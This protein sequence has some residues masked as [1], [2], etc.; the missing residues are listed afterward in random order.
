MIRT[1]CFSGANVV[2]L[3]T[4]R[5]GFPAHSIKGASGTFS[6]DNGRYDQNTRRPGPQPPERGPR[7][8][9]PQTGGH[10]RAFGFGQIVAGL[11]HD[12]CRGTA[13]LYGDAFDLRPAVRGDDG[14]SRRGQ[15]HGTEPRGGH[16]AEDHQQESPFDGRHRHRDQ[17]LSAPPL[18]AG[19]AGLFARHGRGDGPLFRRPDRRSD[20]HGLRR[21]QDRP[22]G[23]RG[24]GPQGPLPRTVRIAGQEGLH[25][26]PHRRRDP[27]NILRDAS[28]PLQDTHHRPGGGPSDSERRIPRAADDLA[29]GVDAAGQG[30]DGRLRLRHR[31]AALLFVPPDVPLDGHGF[32]GPCAPHLFVQLPEGR[33]PSLQRTGRGGGVRHREDHPRHPAFA[34][35]RGRRAAGQVPQQHAL[36]HPRDAGPPLRFHAGRSRRELFRGGVERRAVRRF[37]TADGRSFGVQLPGRTAVPFVG[38]CRR[39]YRPH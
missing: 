36:R 38:G 5:A 28:R 25:L 13:P 17:R 26:R 12:L 18:C 19:V 15:D 11:R 7:N 10:H 1:A 21:A 6:E 3:R 4:F 20:P 29:E 37:R 39:V 22:D 24:E 2:S 9:A 33:L 8:P 32:R 34:A 30:N 14:A 16:R 31:T 27:R 23:P 35:R